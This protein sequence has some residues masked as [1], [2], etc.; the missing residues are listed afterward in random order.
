MIPSSSVVVVAAAAT[1]FTTFRRSVVFLPITSSEKE[2]L[3]F[4]LYFKKRPYKCEDAKDIF[5]FSLSRFTRVCVFS[6]GA[7]LCVRALV[8]KKGIRA[9]P[10]LPKTAIQLSSPISSSHE[11]S[12]E[13][14]RREKGGDN[15]SRKER[16]FLFKFW[17]FRKT[18]QL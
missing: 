18:V 14:K 11:R 17:W 5:S 10:N 4:T 15:S 8:V 2:H 1:L 7:G 6:R 9:C 13:H 16:D 12:F 3:C